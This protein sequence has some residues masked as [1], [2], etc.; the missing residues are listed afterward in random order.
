M[1]TQIIYTLTSTADYINESDTIHVKSAIWPNIAYKSA[2]ALVR[3]W[4]IACCR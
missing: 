4:S 1:H 3:A 2:E